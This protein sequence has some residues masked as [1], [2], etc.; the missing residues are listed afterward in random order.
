MDPELKLIAII[1][2]ELKIERIQHIV[3]VRGKKRC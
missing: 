2:R 3:I 1:I